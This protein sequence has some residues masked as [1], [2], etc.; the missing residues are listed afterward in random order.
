MP[1][2]FTFSNLGLRAGGIALL[3]G[4][5]GGGSD[6]P[7][8]E[9]SGGGSAVPNAGRSGGTAGAGESGAGAA[10]GTAGTTNAAG[11]GGAAIGG[12]PAS[13][14]TAGS[15]A[16]APDGSAGTPNGTAGASAAGASGAS[17]GG[18]T[19]SG[20][21]SAGGG[22]SAGAGNVGP[23]PP[24]VTRLFPGSG[25]SGVCLDAPLTMT[26]AAAP[27]LGTK[28]TIAIYAK[29]N[30]STAVDSVDIAASSYSDV[31]GG[32]TRNLVRPVFVDGTSAVIYLRRHKLS[33]NTAYFVTVS[34]GTFV[35][36]QKNAIGTVSGQTAWTF[37]TGAAPTAATAMPV[38]RTGSGPFCTVQGA[39]DAIPANDATTR[40]ITV[41]AGNYHEL[42]YLSGKKNLTLRGAD[43]A[44]TVIRYPNNDKLNAGTSARPMFFANGTTDLTIENLT[45]YNTT[46]QDGS[47]A[48]ALRVQADRVT[49]RDVNLKSLQ[50]TLLTAGSV[51]VV[52]SYLEGNVDFV[53]GNGPTY[54][55][56]CEIKT[57]G[58]AGAIVQ[59]RNG[60]TGYGYV[61][62]DS[63]ITSD[64][65]VTGQV[66]AR[67][68]A[69]VYPASNVAF[70]NCQMS[71][72][73]AAKGWTIT[74]AGTSATGQLR[75]WE[76]QS[77]DA[78][79]ALL[80]VSGRD[81]AS[82]Q[83]SASEAATLRNK[84]TVLNGW[85]PQ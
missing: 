42:L 66:L 11:R 51:Y 21:A 55:D 12:A 84:P 43:R 13:G 9:Q 10:P 23:L 1:F 27:T 46:P 48:E 75:L 78:S 25:T 24:S 7:S 29:S 50:D 28:G 14:G 64:A 59:A 82:K 20:G 45:L 77:T 38:N 22:G 79:G 6:A 53:W 54:F 4:A 39:F 67:I 60:G 31:I 30:P 41:A 61:F 32:Q 37:T 57:V 44:G 26:F 3:L 33:A 62:V 18:S 16:G 2:R 52:N 72:G 69:T 40:T 49:I 8:M 15:S 35:D 19:G 68:D 81:P 34:S 36:A 73:I 74:P 5:C 47:Q 17:V 85:N 83:L 63:K 70:L 56:R 65:K 80:N 76:Y 71:S 58:R